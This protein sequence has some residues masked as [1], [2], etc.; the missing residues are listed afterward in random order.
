[1]TRAKRADFGDYRIRVSARAKYVSIK[2]SHLGEV[3]IVVPQGFDK[4]KLP[5]IIEQRRDWIA[6]TTQRVQAERGSLSR[7][8]G[9]LLPEKLSLRALAEEW[10]ITYRATPGAS[11]SL[12][13][14]GRHALLVYGAIANTDLCRRVLQRW[15]SH[16][17]LQHFEP[18]LQQVSQQT[19]LPFDKVSVRGQKTRWASCSSRKTISLN[20]KLLFLPPD[21]VRYVFIHE[22]CH[23]VHLNHSSKFWGL[24]AQKLPGYEPIDQEVGKAWRYVPEWVEQ[25][26]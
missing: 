6:K 3:E 19:Q 21:L 2:V 12:R 7:E 25:S 5:D 16:K 22:L 1:M 18:W 8:S 17:A 26:R 14:T 9:I 23:T 13:P 15:L 10:T 4:G 20:Y 11:V 24:V